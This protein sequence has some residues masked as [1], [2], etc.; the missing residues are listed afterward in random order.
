[1]TEQWVQITKRRLST[2]HIPILEPVWKPALPSYTIY[3]DSLHPRTLPS[4]TIYGPPPSELREFL[5]YTYIGVRAGEARGAAAPPPKVWATQI[6]W[7]ARENL[8]KAS[9]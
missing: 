3:S 1:M 6:F 2:S 8:G 4:L 9:F 7:A 5:R